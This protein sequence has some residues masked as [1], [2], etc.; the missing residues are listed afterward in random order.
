MLVNKD[1]HKT[2]VTTFL[3]GGS[4]TSLLLPPGTENPSYATGQVNKVHA[5]EARTS[6]R[7]C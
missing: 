7:T 3:A 2:F 5:R 1:Y 6:L 4:R